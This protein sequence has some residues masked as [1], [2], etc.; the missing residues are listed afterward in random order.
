MNTLVFEL[1]WPP[2]EGQVS[3]KVV[4]PAPA[5]NTN[6]TTLLCGKVHCNVMY[7]GAVQCGT[8]G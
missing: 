1:D 4:A 7:K 6:D 8:M 2:W 3:F 5:P